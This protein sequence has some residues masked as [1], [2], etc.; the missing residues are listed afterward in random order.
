M[1]KSHG[2][3]YPERCYDVHTTRLA[4]TPDKLNY[5][6]ECCGRGDEREREEVAERGRMHLEKE[7]SKYDEPR[8]GSVL[9]RRERVVREAKSVESWCMSYGVLGENEQRTL[10]KGVLHRA[11]EGVYSGISRMRKRQMILGLSVDAGLSG[12]YFRLCGGN[13][14]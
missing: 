4:W 6:P 13:G 7:L 8:K 3:K 1:P 10:R 11:R 12:G 2:L 5:G 9:K 14:D